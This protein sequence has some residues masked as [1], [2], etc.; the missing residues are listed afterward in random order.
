MTLIERR[1]HLIQQINLIDDESILAML[2]DELIFH[3][4]YDNCSTDSLTPFERSEL[5][6]LASDT[7]DKDTVTLEEYR[8]ATQRWRTK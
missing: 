2:E 4:Q 5:I 1:Q 3:L 7:T 8:A 6:A